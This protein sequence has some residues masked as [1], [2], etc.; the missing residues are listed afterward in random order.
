MEVFESYNQKFDLQMQ[1]LAWHASNVMNVHLKKR[2]TPDR[3]LGKKK[4]KNMTSI[5]RENEID[6]LRVAL[7]KRR[8]RNGSR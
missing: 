3:L 6:K 4:E 2:V 5:D 8:V 1:M 7:A